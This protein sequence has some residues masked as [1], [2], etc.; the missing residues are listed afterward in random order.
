M[1]YLACRLFVALVRKEW[2]LVGFVLL[3]SAPYLFSVTDAQGA[4]FRLYIEGL[5][6][7]LSLSFLAQLSAIFSERKRL[8]RKE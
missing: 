4:R 6:L 7:M 8:L 3:F 2:G 1:C 5:I